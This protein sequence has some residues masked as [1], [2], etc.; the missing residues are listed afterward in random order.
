MLISQR[1]NFDGNLEAIGAQA[2]LKNSFGV[3]AW[4]PDERPVGHVHLFV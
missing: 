1:D 4:R 3:R 2:A